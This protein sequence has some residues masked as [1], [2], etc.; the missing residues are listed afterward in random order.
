MPVTNIIDAIQQKYDG[1]TAFSGKPAQLVFGP[2]W[3]RNEA[4]ALVGYPLVRFTHDGTDTPTDFEYSPL[5]EWSFT[6]EVFAQ[7][8]QQALHIFDRIRS[9]GSD[10]SAAAGFWYASTVAMPAGY[11]FLSFQPA[12]GFTVETREGQYSPTGAFVHVVT[13]RMQLQVHRTSFE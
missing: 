13:F 10:P 2:V 4:G 6:F 12:G 5:E 7:T 1:L 8:A 11:T 3:P 9:N